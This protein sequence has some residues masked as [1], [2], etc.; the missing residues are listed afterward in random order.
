MNGGEK[1]LTVHSITVQSS[2]TIYVSNTLMQFVTTVTQK[3]QVTIPKYLRE[4]FK[5]KRMS[6]VAILASRN[7]L[8]I[9]PLEDIVD[10]AG[11]LKPK[12]KRSILKARAE[13]E[14]S[15]HRV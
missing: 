10:L 15:Y 13:M 3:G 6:K 9:Q 2:N 12:Q 7:Q 1:S 11:T 14:R 8:V 4:A 5:I